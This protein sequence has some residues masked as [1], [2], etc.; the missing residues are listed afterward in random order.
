[1]RMRLFFLRRRAE[2]PLLAL[3]AHEHQLKPKR[4]N[5][6]LAHVAAAV[7]ALLHCACSL[8]VHAAAQK[9]VSESLGPWSTANLREARFSLAATSLPN[10]GLAIFAGG[11]GTSCDFYCDDCREGCGVRGVR[12]RRGM[13]AWEE[14]VE[15]SVMPRCC[16]QV[17][18]DISQL[19][20]SSMR[21]RETGAL[22][23]SAKLEVPWPPH[24]C[25]IKDSRSSLAA[26]VRRVTVIA[27]IA[28][29]RVV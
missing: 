28:E 29:R 27:M 17:P 8:L 25:R 12:G 6:W 7:A 2:R 20:T 19:W 15:R 13:H 26:A 5:R 23:F 16:V 4:R 3:G 11:Q 1:M 24:R 18:V 14:R 22:Q 21:S 9:V 10:Q